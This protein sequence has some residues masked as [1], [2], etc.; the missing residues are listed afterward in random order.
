MTVTPK[1]LENLKKGKA[2]QFSG[3]RAASC[4]RKGQAKSAE[5]RVKRRTLCELA[6]VFGQAKVDPKTEQR[7]REQ[8]IEN[9]DDMI[10]DMAMICGLY[11]AAKRGSAPAAETLAKLKGALNQAQIN[12]NNTPIIIGGENDLQD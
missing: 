11:A 9:A 10:Q 4:G 7:L 12:I 3:E 2:T 8:G 5:S 6:D 1:Q